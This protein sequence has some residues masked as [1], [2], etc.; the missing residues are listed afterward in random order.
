MILVHLQRP[1]KAKFLARTFSL[2]MMEFDELLPLHRVMRFVASCAKPRSVSMRLT[3]GASTIP[4][5]CHALFAT[6]HN[7][8][9][10]QSSPNLLTLT[11]NLLN[12]P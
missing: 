11:S 4:C 9:L 5:V 3:P 2:H 12:N 6:G 8:Q 10:W 7:S 1:R